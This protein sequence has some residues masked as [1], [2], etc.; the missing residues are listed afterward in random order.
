M[1]RPVGRDAQTPHT[2]DEVDVVIAGHGE[3]VNGGLRRP[4]QAGELPFVAAGGEHRFENF[5][6][7][8]SAWVLFHGPHGGEA[9]QPQDCA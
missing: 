7:D 6:N 2:R 9:S 1:Y 4:F 8:F 5:S 3:F